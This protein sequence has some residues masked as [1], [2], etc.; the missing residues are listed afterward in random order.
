[1]GDEDK[2]NKGSNSN[3]GGGFTQADVDRIVAD[4][5]ARER[6][7]YADYD[8]L[9]RKAADADKTKS[10]VDKLTE[11]VRTLTER[12]EKAEIAT[13]KREV[14]D[15]FKLPKSFANRLG[16]KTTE[17]L[18]REARE[19]VDELKSLGV[20]LDKTSGDGGKD[21]GKDGGK[22]GGKAGND[23]GNGGGKGGNGG[24]SDGGGDDVDPADR[25]LSGGRPKESLRSGV[26]AGGGSGDFDYGKEA[27]K[28]L[29]GGLI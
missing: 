10:D 23:A 14:A 8:E 27:D 11:A 20:D 5:L 6:G 24:G 13:M 29:S 21:A 18:E 9:K 12:A 28:I 1:M 25:P 7:K 26:P 16:G 3:S 22:D 15:R 4:R 19:M 2:D 17:D